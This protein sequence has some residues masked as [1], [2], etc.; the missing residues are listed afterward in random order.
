MLRRIFLT[1][2]LT[3]LAMPVFAEDLSGNWTAYGMNP[4]GSKYTGQVV[5]Q[6][7]AKGK[8]TFAWTVGKQNY[9]GQGVHDGR[10]VVVDWGD[11]TPV[12]YVEMPN[13]ELHGTWSGGTALERLVRR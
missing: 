4:D 3:F 1:L 9:T 11:S 13:G 8:V 6:E 10:V 12:V 5:I 2:A 7:G